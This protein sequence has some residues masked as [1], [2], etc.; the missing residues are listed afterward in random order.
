MPDQNAIYVFATL[1][2]AAGKEAALRQILT[3]L[4][5]ATRQEPG[6]LLYHLHEGTQAPG[7]FLVYEAYRDKAAV[8]AHM[9]SAHLQGALAAASPLLGAAPVIIPAS[10]IV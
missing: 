1:T 6:N 2:A 4:V 8:E 3:D 10:Q 9:A 5:N 7:T